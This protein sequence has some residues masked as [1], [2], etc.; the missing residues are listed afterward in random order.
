MIRKPPRT[1]SK[2][3]QPIPTTSGDGEAA[4]APAPRAE[5][6]P[7]TPRASATPDP[8]RQSQHHAT[9]NLA[10][11]VPPQAQSAT[12]PALSA[13]SMTRQG[14]TTDVPPPPG[15]RTTRVGAFLSSMPDQAAT[16]VMVG[17]ALVGVVLAVRILA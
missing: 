14:V 10:P 1:I 15:M 2:A 7:A 6:V 4:T 16:F 11:G 12:G 9:L 17:V 3:G 5:A 8:N 13:V